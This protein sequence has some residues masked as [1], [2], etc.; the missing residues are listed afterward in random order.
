[1]EAIAKKVEQSSSAYPYTSCVRNYL[2]T[3]NVYSTRFVEFNQGDGI[4]AIT[5]TLFRKGERPA[6]A[7]FSIKEIGAKNVAIEKVFKATCKYL[8]KNLQKQQQWK[9]QGLDD[10]VVVADLSTPVISDQSQNVI[11]TGNESVERQAND[12]VKELSLKDWSSTEEYYTFVSD[13]SAVMK[14]WF[15]LDVVKVD[16]SIT[17]TQNGGLFKSWR[18]PQDLIEN[19]FDSINILPIRG[20]MKGKYS[21]L[22]KMILQANT[23]QQGLF[24]MSAYPYGYGAQT[25][26]NVSQGIRP[27]ASDASANLHSSAYVTSSTIDNIDYTAAVQRPSVLIDI[28]SGGEVELLVE[29][30]YHKTL[31]RNFDSENFSNVNPG[32]RGSFFA[33]LQ[34][35][36]LSQLR[37]G[38]G[39]NSFNIRVLYQFVH[40]DLTAMVPV[41]SKKATLYREPTIIVK[42][43]HYN[44]ALKKIEEI[45]NLSYGETE[46][47]HEAYDKLRE[48]KYAELSK[49]RVQGPAMSFIVGTKIVTDITNNVIRMFERSGASNRR[50]ITPRNRDKPND[51]VSLVRTTPRPRG[52]FTNGVGVDD[53]LVLGVSWDELTNF[54]SEVT[55]EPKSFRELARISGVLGRFVWTTQDAAQKELFTWNVHP[56]MVPGNNFRDN[57]GANLIRH[58]LG[59]AASCF[60][61]YWGTI[62]LMFQFVKT[63]SH[64]GAVE[65][66][67]YF[68]GDTSGEGL[69]STYVKILNIQENPCF[70]VTIPYIYDTSVRYIAGTSTPLY[71]SDLSN[72]MEYSFYHTARVRVSITNEL[73]AV[74]VVSQEVECL[75]WIRGGSDFGFNWPH[76]ANTTAFP[77]NYEEPICQNPMTAR[78]AYK[79]PDPQVQK[80]YMLDGSIG[81]LN[82]ETFVAQGDDDF[83]QRA[84][85]GNRV[86]SVEHDDF[87]TLCK[88][89]VKILSDFTYEPTSTHK[90]T[91]LRQTAQF[92]YKLRNYV[93]V[94]VCPLNLSLVNFLNSQYFTA[95][96]T[97]AATGPL[98]YCKGNFES[99]KSIQ[100]Q[101]ASMFTF[102]RGGLNY[103]I[104]LTE[105]TKPVYFAYAPH[106]YQLRSLYGPLANTGTLIYQS[107]GDGKN[108]GI[109]GGTVGGMCNDDH[110]DL[111]MTGLYNGFLVPSVN[112]TE[113]VQIPMSTQNNYLLMN[114]DQQYRVTSVHSRS[115]KTMRENS[116][117][118]NG[119]LMLWS[120]GNFKFDLYLSCADDYEMMGFIGHPGMSN[121]K[122]AFA[123]MDNWRTQ[124]VLDFNFKDLTQQGWKSF[125]N[126][127]FQVGLAAGLGTL[128]SSFPPEIASITGAI[129]LYGAIGGVSQIVELKNRIENKCI[130]AVTAL[131]N[132]ITNI[133]SDTIIQFLKEAFP[134]LKD[135]LTCVGSR[136]WSIAQNVIHASLASNWRNTSFAVFNIMLELKVM[137]TSDWL[138][139]KEKLEECV[140]N[141]VP[142]G[143]M[144]QGL[145]DIN[146]KAI[147]ENWVPL[148]ELITGII[149]MKFQ[150]K[151]C[152]SLKWFFEDIFKYQNYRNITGLN[153]ILSFTRC[154]FKA[155]QTIVQHCLEKVDPTIKLLKTLQDKK[156]ELYTFV[157]EANTF[158]NVFVESDFKKKNK[159]VMYLATILRAYKLKAILLK[160]NNPR[161]TSQLITLCD[162]VV[163]KAVK[164]RYLFRCD[165][166]K[167]EPFVIFIEGDAG[168][169]K[170]FSV[171][172]LA[173]ELL[174]SNGKSY[175]HAGLVYT[176]SPGVAYW[177]G[178]DDEPVIWYDDWCN[179]M[180]EE[181]I[182][183]HLQ[184]LYAMKTSSPFN[185][186]RAECENK[187]QIATPE[188]VVATT[189]NP[190]VKSPMIACAKAVF[191]RRD[192]LVRFSTKDGR[193]VKSF[194]QAELENFEHLEVQWYADP[195]VN[196]IQSAK[197]TYKEFL[198]ELK[199][200]YA[201]HREQEF[202]NQSQKYKSLMKAVETNSLD[203]VDIGN[204]FKAISE[205]LALNPDEI[206]EEL[207]NCEI[208]E[209]LHFIN[210]H[211]ENIK[212]GLSD[213]AIFAKEA[214]GLSDFRTQ[215]ASPMEMVDWF[216]NFPVWTNKKI[217]NLHAKLSLYTQR[218]ANCS[219]YAAMHGTVFWCN[220]HAH[221]ICFHCGIVTGA[222]YQREIRTD[223]SPSVYDGSALCPLSE[224]FTN[225]EILIVK[226]EGLFTSIWKQCLGDAI[227]TPVDFINYIRSQVSGEF[228]YSA[229]YGLVIFARMAL[230]AYTALL[231]GMANGAC[232]NR[233]QS[234]LYSTQGEFDEH[235]FFMTMPE[236]QRFLAWKDRGC[237]DVVA[238]SQEENQHLYVCVGDCGF[239]D[240]HKGICKCAV[241]YSILNN[242]LIEDR[243]NHEQNFVD[244]NHQYQNHFYKARVISDFKLP[245]AQVVAYEEFWNPDETIDY[246]KIFEDNYHDISSTSS[247]KIK[248]ACPHSLLAYGFIYRSGFYPI[249][250]NMQHFEL[251]D[252]LCSSACVLTNVRFLK[253]IREKFQYSESEVDDLLQGIDLHR[254]THIIPQFLRPEWIRRAIQTKEQLGVTLSKDWWTTYISPVGQWF[255]KVVKSIVPILVGCGILWGSWKLAGKTWD[256]LSKFFGVNVVEGLHNSGASPSRKPKAR[257]K[258]RTPFKSQ[259]AMDENLENKIN[260]AVENYAILTAKG[261]SIVVWGVTSC[262]FLIPKHLCDA[263]M[264]HVE[265]QLKRVGDKYPQRSFLTTNL[266]IT[267]FESDDLC[268]A[269]ILRTA[270]IFS[271]CSHLIRLAS[272]DSNLYEGL[273]VECDPKS[274]ELIDVDVQIYGSIT[275]VEAQV[276]NTE[277]LYTTKNAIMYNHQKAGMCGSLLFSKSIRPIV[278]MHVA[279]SVNTGKGIGVLLRSELFKVQGFN[280]DVIEDTNEETNYY[281]DD[282]LIEYTASISKDL[283]PYVPK[284]TNIIPSLISPLFD[285]PSTMA[286][287]I[288]NPKDPE[289]KHD[290]SPLFYGVCK[291]GYPSKDF[292]YKLLNVAFKGVSGM[293][294]NPSKLMVK[295]KIR[296]FEEAIVGLIDVPHE[297]KFADKEDPY[298][299]SL[300]LDT[301]SGYP[302]SSNRYRKEFGIKGTNKEEWLRV[303][304]RED[305]RVVSCD[306]HEKLMSDLCNN[307]EKRKKGIL[308]NNI[309]QDCLKDEKRKLE[310]RAKKGGTR[311]FSMSNLEGTIA[312]RQYTLDLTSYLRY[313]RLDNWIGVGINVDSME[314]TVMIDRLLTMSNNIFTLDFTNFGAGLNAGVASYFADLTCM[315]FKKFS[316]ITL[317][318]E[319]VICALIW[320]L[321]GSRHVAGNLIYA[322]SSGSPSGA[323]IT[324]EIN[325][326]VHLMY[327]GVSFLVVG[328]VI[329]G[330][331]NVIRQYPKLWEY[332]KTIKQKPKAFSMEDFFTNVVGVVYGDD[333]QFA[334]S[335][336]YKDV[337]NALTINLVLTQHGIG[338]T[339][340]TKTEKITPYTGILESSFLKRSPKR[341]E[342][343]PNLIWFAAIEENSIKECC[344]WIHKKP[345]VAS[346]ATRENCISALHLAY[347]HG[348]EYYDNFRDD[349]NK[350]LN[351]VGLNSIL[352]E[353]EEIVM[354]FY[355]DL[356]IK[357]F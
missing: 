315:F 324:V 157:D 197:Q 69:K 186:P 222:K 308:A 14:R 238:K 193:S 267:K 235:N 153:S 168:V 5:L 189:N 47:Q 269:T 196:E 356:C 28:A 8:D 211:K 184:Q 50:G 332:L 305:G 179:L 145:A 97:A 11:I 199:V 116:E 1:M 192:V 51:A 35:H 31:I 188:I 140:K 351:S 126:S 259:M 287:A 240:W 313:N 76:P 74:S 113:K 155:I 252:K 217:K 20:F 78:T 282:V 234:Q 48:K 131:T 207:L 281:G 118:F 41:M 6:T 108:I 134:F 92:D 44:E 150:I 176:V 19:N 286:P 233:Y 32:L 312:L 22:F 16:S 339:D 99:W 120:N 296:S 331:E 253:I 218:C 271:D 84:Y 90:S 144:T 60:T 170:S 323:A 26:L 107:G 318:D 3:S 75:V 139:V 209:L 17:P 18:I 213:E 154:M 216:R 148:M 34:L 210:L 167:Q 39:S 278:A 202:Y 353:W 61:N 294:L 77:Q 274:M 4:Y 232:A 355:P 295:P 284:E 347:A 123:M 208:D 88:M 317:E 285:E 200:R 15:P 231:R 277:T 319:K 54:M 178:F 219:S 341:C 174:K 335:D 149:C 226:Q 56:T 254:A 203:D 21:I 9:T 220:Q 43:K 130:P 288:L 125:K 346:V 333:G 246:K 85:Q 158:L 159:R 326:F 320:E 337:F 161:L 136:L 237:Y 81:H 316:T 298:F 201:K 310:K 115:L 256:F 122:S 354:K 198:N 156:S 291:N 67:I 206:T 117:W 230:F 338:V 109:M 344:R 40:A 195:T 53:A 303:K 293:I 105:G 225:P 283:V 328:Q 262:S 33:A 299:D 352:I 160:S 275:N 138:K 23:F 137:D 239:V 343:M 289:Y 257:G 330:N 212:A 266:E 64:R 329:N 248:Y 194:T 164:M 128:G 152:G 129:A 93:C 2:A 241:R 227:Q 273:L 223:N 59:I 101:I 302:Y 350:K 180:D 112:P 142:E 121:T 72:P 66:A 260:K 119:T 87:K 104:V 70:K 292:P 309:F 132:E 177:N 169:G 143:F 162:K 30:K 297:D 89:P 141:L 261:T 7:V 348:K 224:D 55:D 13:K 280:F 38:T 268:L 94:P 73:S 214:E 151:G 357:Y 182:R 42:S 79:S 243:I 171:Y 166:V 102:F 163:D 83:I 321:I 190:F 322:T 37:F 311:L 327:V 106:D 45:R 181:T 175:G 127:M 27:A 300:P 258:V 52:N 236:L 114:R 98:K 307:M 58:P 135:N 263:L 12:P 325:S 71:V 110:V 264:R 304:R 111:A 215:G 250:S 49:Y 103:T 80:V 265:F 349:I 63:Q 24:L 86:T 245:E 100:C 290:K 229:V 306:V 25:I 251:P 336:E 57:F 147:S 301:S 204:P 191:R 96:S 244:C 276:G 91:D 10:D 124:G 221:Y 146:L 36:C 270:P 46:A 228:N 242:F 314:W 95:K 334:V 172:D 183:G 173:G 342:L 249:H 62:E 29:Q 82:S 68:G 279:G 165:I 247:E 185:V 345:L 133:G 272:D 340:A 205:H 65:V 255:V 187:E